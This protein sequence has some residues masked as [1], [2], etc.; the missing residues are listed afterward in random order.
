[1][2]AEFGAAFHMRI[3]VN[4]ID[5]TAIA[6]APHGCERA[7][8]AELLAAAD[9]V[10]LHLPLEP[11]TQGFLSRAHLAAMKPGAFLINTA[12]GELVD[13]AALVAALQ[14]GALTG[15]AVDVLAGDGRW[16]AVPKPHALVALARTHP[17]CIVTPHIGGYG[18]QSLARTRAFV[19]EKLARHVRTADQ[20]A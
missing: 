8:L 6:R 15:A 3:L 1:M 10:T 9:V 4:D 5:E 17:R 16:S 18:K 7:T 13:E 19:V 12:R 11:A 14:S 20:G 2:V